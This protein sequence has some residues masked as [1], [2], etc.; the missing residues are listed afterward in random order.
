MQAQ[1]G[2]RKDKLGSLVFKDIL[3]KEILLWKHVDS[4]LVKDY[5]QQLNILLDLGYE[6][7]AIII[8][9]KRGLYKAF[10]KESDAKAPFHFTRK[11][12]LSKCVIFINER[13]LTVI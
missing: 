7:K 3:S 11:T 2:K 8:D 13:Q 12:F 4:E 1:D 10:L 5:K 9:G 6:V